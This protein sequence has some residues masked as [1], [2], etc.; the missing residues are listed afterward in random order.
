MKKSG[1]PV[2]ETEKPEQFCTF[3]VQKTDMRIP[4]TSLI[5]VVD[6]IVTGSRVYAHGRRFRGVGAR[7]FAAPER[8][9]LGEG[10]AA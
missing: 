1:K 9:R 3:A 10:V 4:D 5:V 2:S 6:R 8:C 7:C